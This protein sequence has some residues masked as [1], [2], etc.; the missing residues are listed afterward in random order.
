M[1]QKTGTNLSLLDQIVSDE[2][3]KESESENQKDEYNIEIAQKQD[4]GTQSSEFD[5]YENRIYFPS[6]ARRSTVNFQIREPK[7]L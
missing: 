7:N 3:L 4:G 6:S 5:M 2:K 1:V